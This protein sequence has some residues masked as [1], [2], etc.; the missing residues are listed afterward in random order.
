MT[1]IKDWINGQV[2]CIHIKKYEHYEGASQYVTRFD[3]ILSS[4]QL[5]K[6]NDVNKKLEKKLQR[7]QNAITLG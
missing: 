5:Q 7:L 2:G 6:K 1:I 4:K 3:V